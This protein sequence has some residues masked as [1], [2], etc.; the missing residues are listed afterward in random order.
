MGLRV[1]R[2]TILPVGG[3]TILGRTSLIRLYVTYQLLD[4]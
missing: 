4:L 1:I 3:S 2:Y